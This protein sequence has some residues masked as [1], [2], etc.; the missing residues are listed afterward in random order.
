MQKFTNA[1][2]TILAL[3]AGASIVVA[4]SMAIIKVVIQLK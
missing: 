4:F 1:V 3:I 2:I